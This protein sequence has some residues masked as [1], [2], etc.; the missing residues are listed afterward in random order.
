MLS[1]KAIGTCVCAVYGAIMMVAATPQPSR[2]LSTCAFSIGSSAVKGSCGRV[3]DQTL[4][5][6][7]RP[8]DTVLGGSWRSGSSPKAVSYGDMTDEGHPNAPI[9][10]QIY[11]GASG[12]LQTIYGWFPVT[13][14][15]TTSSGFAFELD[16]VS[17][18]PPNALDARIIR[19]AAEMLSSTAVWNRADDRNCAPKATTFS[20]YCAGEKAIEEIT[21]GTGL[22]DHR[23]PALEVIRGVVDDRSKGRSYHHR[24][25]NYNNDPTT[26][27]SDVQSLFSEALRV[28]T[29]SAWLAAHGFSTKD[30]NK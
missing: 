14:F 3:F 24:L 17:E 28:M 12:I 18:V 6:T 4:R 9:Q 21:G 7:L 25:M 23:R 5:M 26:T 27:L 8:S 15:R 30:L 2:V 10:L 22:I 29:D 13:G 11:S 16:G 1:G 19:R 20:I